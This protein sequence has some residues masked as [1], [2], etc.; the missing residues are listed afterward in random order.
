MYTDKY[1]IAYRQGKYKEIDINLLDT[2]YEPTE[3]EYKPL[4]VKTKF[5]S[6]SKY[7]DIMAEIESKIGKLINV[8]ELCRFYNVPQSSFALYLGRWADH[9]GYKKITNVNGKGTKLIKED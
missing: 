5:K 6:N 7:R 8:T 4:E 1:D 2:E 9:Y 3:V